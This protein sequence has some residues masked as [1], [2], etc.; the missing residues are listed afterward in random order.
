M[1]GPD[2]TARDPALFGYL[3]FLAAALWERAAKLPFETFPP[4]DLA[5]ADWIREA[6]FE[7]MPPFPL[8]PPDFPFAIIFPP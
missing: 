1:S 8:L 5:A 7:L 3:P 6:A 2:P 4:P